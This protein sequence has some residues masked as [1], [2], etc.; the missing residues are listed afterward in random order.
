M[1]GG[2]ATSNHPYCTP[3]QHLAFAAVGGDTPQE[4]LLSSFSQSTLSL[5]RHSAGAIYAVAAKRI[6]NQERKGT[7]PV[8][9]KHRDEVID[10]NKYDSEEDHIPVI[11]ALCSAS[12]VDTEREAFIAAKAAELTKKHHEEFMKRAF[13]LRVISTIF[14]LPLHLR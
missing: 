14:P 8:Y 10:D 12:T 11:N 7:H 9:D 1:T 13:S 6:K 4:H 3:S 2:G 5:S